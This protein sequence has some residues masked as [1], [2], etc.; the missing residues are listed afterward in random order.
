MLGRVW[1]SLA[2]PP[3]GVSWVQL[4]AATVFILAVALA[5]RQVTAYI[6]REI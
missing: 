1:S 3:S 5:W 2:T 4:G 6:L